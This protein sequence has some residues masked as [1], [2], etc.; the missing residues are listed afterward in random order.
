MP[1]PKYIAPLAFAITAAKSFNLYD[2]F[3]ASSIN[4]GASSNSLERFL[5]DSVDS[6]PFMVPK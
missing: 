1:R 5:F 4:L 6:V 3:I 2:R